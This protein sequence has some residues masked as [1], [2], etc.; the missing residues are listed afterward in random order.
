MTFKTE[1]GEETYVNKYQQFPGETWGDRARTVVSFVCGDM[2]GK[3]NNL[4]GKEDQG[5]LVRFIEEMKFM[6]GGR[7]LWYAGRPAPF[8]NNCYLLRLEEDTRE[9]WAS[10]TERAMSCLMTGGG[11]G[12]DISLCRPHGRSL[13]RT[14]GI[15]SGPIPLLYTVNEVG[16]NVMQGGSRRSAMYGSMD[17]DHGDVWRFLHAK[18]WHDMPIAGAFTADGSP[19]TIADAKM[20]DFNYPAPL[21]MMNISINYS[22]EWLDGGNDEVFMENCRQALMTGEP[23]FSFNFGDKANETLRNACCEIVSSDDSDVCNLGSVN[24]AN[25]ESIEELKDVVNLASKFLVCGL[26]RAHLPYDKVSE[27]RQKNSRLGLGLM[28]VHE[29]LLQRGYQYEMTDEL[30]K[31][32]KVYEHESKRSADE[33]CNRLYLQCPKGYRAVAPTGTI[34]IIAGTTGGVEPLYSVAYR[35]RFLVDGTKWKY[36]YVVDGTAQAIKERYGYSNEQMDGLENAEALAADP[37][38][39]IKFQFDLQKYID[40][41][42]SSTVNLPE[43]GSELNNESHVENFSKIIRKYG[44]GLR[45]LT[46]YPDGSRGGQ[47]IKAVPY[48]EAI[49]KRGLIYEDNSEEQCLS[50]VCGI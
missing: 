2:F 30:K 6:P 7:Y 40:H 15:S 49:S 12:M 31:W 50:G 16:R 26:V 17:A 37:E 21:D 9:E 48:S 8:L 18:N 10:L 1:F 25:I 4:L 11:I 13:S 19:M 32:M 38:R 45:G 36:K 29:W 42:V 35:R 43:W 39:R 27:V 5:Q 44:H 34:S 24:L 14:G 47:P 20:A 33:H 23:G 22:D 28:G 41:A 46:F 3:S